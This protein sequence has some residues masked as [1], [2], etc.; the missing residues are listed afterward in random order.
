MR[1]FVLGKRGNRTET[2]KKSR[3]T[4]SQIVAILKEVDSGLALVHV[5]LQKAI[6]I[7]QLNREESPLLVGVDGNA[8]GVS[9]RV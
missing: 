5:V 3:F 2:M 1:G 4:E 6:L 8:G 7:L 9:H